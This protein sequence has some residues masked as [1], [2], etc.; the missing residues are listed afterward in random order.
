M[1]KYNCITCNYSTD[2]HCN[3]QKHLISKKHVEKS[4]AEKQLILIKSQSVTSNQTVG[5][6]K[7]KCDFCENCYSGAN[8]LAKHKKSCSEKRKLLEEIKIKELDASNKQKELETTIKELSLKLIHKDEIIL[9]KDEI[10]EKEVVNSQNLKAIL[11]SA[12]H[13][14]EKSMSNMNYLNATYT[15][16]PVLKCI[17]YVPSI[18]KEFTEKDFIDIVVMKNKY[19]KLDEFIGDIVIKIYKKDDPKEQSIW[20]SDV[21]RMTYAIRAVLDQKNS[22]A[23]WKVD[24]KGL[25]VKNFIV[26]PILEHIRNRLDKQLKVKNKIPPRSSNEEIIRI[27]ALTKS[28]HDALVRVRDS[29]FEQSILKYIGPPLHIT[30]QDLT[31]E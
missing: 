13:M 7:Y 9:C 23:Y 29:D 10:I 11:T 3:Y 28:I 20:N 8:N 6:L 30:R 17:T 27:N 21:D 12:G 22:K 14:V 4:N 24:K 25:D 2:I 18:S 15:N 19:D 31:L 16:A 1:P 26:K 5:S